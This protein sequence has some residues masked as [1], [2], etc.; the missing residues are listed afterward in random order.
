M[1]PWLHAIISAKKYGGTP[2]DYIKI[3]DFIDSSK[4]HVPDMRH[5]ALLHSS[6]GCFLTEQMY[7]HNI[8]NSEGKQI[9]V[10]DIAEEHIIQDLGFIPTVE[11]YLGNMQLQPWMSG[12]RKTTKTRTTRIEMVD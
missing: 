7:G 11:Q 4:A 2:E 3:H 6:F 8:T 10:R 1:K 12:S 5:R 9:S